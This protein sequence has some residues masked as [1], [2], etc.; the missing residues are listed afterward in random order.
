MFR[1]ICLSS[2]G[3]ALLINR[4]IESMECGLRAIWQIVIFRRLCDEKKE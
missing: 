3:F 4:G 1:Q 2:D